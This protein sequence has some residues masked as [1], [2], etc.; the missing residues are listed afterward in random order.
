MNPL[1]GRLSFTYFSRMIPLFVAVFLMR[2][3]FSFTVVSLQYIVLLPASLG[4]IS[5]AYPVMEMLSGFFIGIVADRFGRKWIISVGLVVSSAVSLAFTFYSNSLYLTVIH[6]IQGVCAAAIVVSTLA[7][8]TDLAKDSTRGR[9]MGAYDFFTIAGY[10]LG[11][12]MALIIINGDAANARIPFYVGAAAA[13]VGGVFSAVFLKDSRVKTGF[14]SLKQNLKLIAEN[15]STQ[16]LLPTWFVLMTV[17]GVFLTFT[18]RISDL[19][20]PRIGPVTRG[21]SSLKLDAVAI[22]LVV[23]GLI[24]LGLSQTTL[25]SLSDRFGRARIALIGQ[26]SLMGLLGV[27]IAMLSFSL[28]LIYALPFVAL[29]GAGLL[30]FTPSALAELADAAPASGRGSIMGVYSVAVGAGTIVGPL[31]G[32]FLIALYGVG[33]GLSILFSVG[34]LIILVFMIPRV[35]Q[36]SRNN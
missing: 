17:V 6:G 8:L 24:L 18:T 34:A 13:L 35:L 9:E 5:S 14:V 10:G 7:L 4:V 2:F 19:L 20:V 32:G 22:V 29:F 30:A 36:F 3:A 33:N 25:G 27:L 31:A 16:T 1:L 21:A 12:F 11:F 15:R 28:R 26:V 23:V